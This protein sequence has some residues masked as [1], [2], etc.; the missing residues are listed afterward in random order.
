MICFSV[1]SLF[2]FTESIKRLIVSMYVF[3]LANQEGVY[4][5][6]TSRSV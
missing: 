6:E 3:R 4:F 2:N 5:S 1:K